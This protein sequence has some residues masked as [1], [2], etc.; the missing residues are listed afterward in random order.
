MGDIPVEPNVNFALTCVKA[1]SHLDTS[2]QQN[3]NHVHPLDLTGLLLQLLFYGAVLGWA[4]C[5]AGKH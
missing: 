5:A 4:V 3:T 2:A 1:K